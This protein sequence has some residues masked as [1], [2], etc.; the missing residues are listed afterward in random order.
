MAFPYYFLIGLEFRNLENPTYFQLLEN[1][2][3]GK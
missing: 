3:N 2:E 1:I